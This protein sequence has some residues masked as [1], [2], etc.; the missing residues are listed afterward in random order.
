MHGGARLF[1]SANPALNGWTVR[2]LESLSRQTASRCLSVEYSLA[3]DV[4]GAQ[5]VTEVLRVYRHLLESGVAP[6][7][8]GFVGESG[9]E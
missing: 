8:I 5:Q 7:K 2:F 6:N 3:P 9:G 1:N 4:N